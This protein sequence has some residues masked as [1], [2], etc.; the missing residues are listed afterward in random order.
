MLA[1]LNSF[2][3]QNLKWSSDAKFSKYDH[4]LKQS[5]C[6]KLRDTNIKN[7]LYILLIIVVYS[8]H[9]NY[10]KFNLKWEN[11]SFKFVVYLS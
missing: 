9:S 4:T 5:V 11:S 2:S 6:L 1:L 3:S 8:N 7:I 10:L